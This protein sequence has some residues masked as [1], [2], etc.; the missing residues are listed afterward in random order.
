MGLLP[1][2]G[3]LRVHLHHGG[4]AYKTV[5]LPERLLCLKSAGLSLGRC[6]QLHTHRC[7]MACSA[8]L[9]L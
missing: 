1:L 8:A 5:G 2:L 3:L 4:A 9:A 7:S 6:Q